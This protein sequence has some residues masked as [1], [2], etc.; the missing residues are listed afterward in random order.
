MV[1]YD[2]LF[3]IVDGSIREQGT[4]D[5][6]VASGGV[7][8]RLWSEQTGAELV[9]PEPVDAVAALGQVSIFAEL[10][11]DDLASV[12]RRL[13]AEELAPGQTIDDGDGRLCLIGRGRARVLGAGFDG[14]TAVI[15]E[16]GEGDVFGVAGLLNG[17][18]SGVRLQAIETTTLLVLDD[19]VIAGLAATHP[20]VAARLEGSL[21]QAATPQ[22]G[23]RLTRMTVSLRAARPPGR[24]RPER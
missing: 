3:V 20:S 5:E 16:L 13:R 6:L 23:Q 9:E 22:G 18:P 12:A 10:T 17:G 2:R 4:H 14:A 7:Y 11:G 24:D 15:A 8:A 21:A 19:T 1:N